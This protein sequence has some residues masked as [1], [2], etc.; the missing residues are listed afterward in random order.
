MTAEQIA[1]ELTYRS[2]AYQRAFYGVTA[3]QAARVYPDAD[4]F[5]ARFQSEHVMLEARRDEP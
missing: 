3:E 2:Y 1:D 5:E 4:A